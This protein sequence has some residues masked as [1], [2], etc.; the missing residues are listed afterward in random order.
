[1]IKLKI[2]SELCTLIIGGIAVLVAYF[3]GY[4]LN[5]FVQ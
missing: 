5:F 3:V 1:M 4:Q 2:R